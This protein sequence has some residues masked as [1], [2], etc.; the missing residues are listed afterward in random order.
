MLRN[1]LIKNSY[2]LTQWLGNQHL[3]YTRKKMTS[4]NLY[5]AL[6]IL[7]PGYVLLSSKNGEYTNPFIPG[8]WKHAAMY[9]GLGGKHPS[10]IE[11]LGQ[12]VVETNLIDFV[13]TKDAISIY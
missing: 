10:V 9:Y 5:E 13:L 11:A 7:K 2:I 4:K 12:G 6:K 3:P 1:Y 8:D